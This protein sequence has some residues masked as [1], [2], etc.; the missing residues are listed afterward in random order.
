M[1]SIRLNGV[2]PPVDPTSPYTEHH[3]YSV[4]LGNRITVMFTS[5]RAAQAF[6]AETDRWISSHLNATNFLLVDAFA[7]YRHA[8]CL[9]DQTSVPQAER[10]AREFI[11]LAWKAMDLAI[12]KASGPN[13]WVIAWKW[14]HQAVESIRLLGLL[15]RDLYKTRNNPVERSRMDLLACRAQ[16]VLNELAQYGQ[17]VKGAIKTREV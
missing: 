17:H 15:L 13:G 7:S 9:L 4:H 8:W 5:E 2:R 3:F 10:Q 16:T 1:K 6:Q 11:E 14:L 12:S